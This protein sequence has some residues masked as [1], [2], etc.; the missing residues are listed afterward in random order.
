MQTTEFNNLIESHKTSFSIEELRGQVDL[1]IDNQEYKKLTQLCETGYTFTEPQCKALFL[2]VLKIDT[3]A[4]YRKNFSNLAY[5][6][7]LKAIM[8]YEKSFA[9]TACNYM[10]NILIDQKYI[11][12][13]SPHRTFFSNPLRGWSMPNSDEELSWASGFLIEL[14]DEMATYV[15]SNRLKQAKETVEQYDF[16]NVSSYQL[17]QMRSTTKE[18]FELSLE[19]HHKSN[20]D[21]MKKAK[22]EPKSE[23]LQI[24]NTN[25]NVLK[26][27][28]SKLLTLPT[29]IQ[30]ATKS[31]KELLLTF[32]VEKLSETES[33]EYH[34]LLANQLP[35]MFD[36]Y[37]KISEKN[38][39]R[40]IDGETANSILNDNITKLKELFT[41]IKTAQEERELAVELT[42]LKINKQYLKLK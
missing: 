21:E 6:Q 16:K 33:L 23:M 29:E 9:K 22:E 5:S 40:V 20:L 17:S 3:S 30:K 2:L 34:N 41:Q 31:L 39:D 37:F 1:L 35:M 11:K 38:R 19:K 13:L 28:E 26:I 18:I 24:E 42:N 12:Q 8:N 14:K 15:P 36:N 27:D 4:S 25:N 10:A 32:E 7:G